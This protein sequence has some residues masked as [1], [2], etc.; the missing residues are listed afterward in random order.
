MQGDYFDASPSK[1]LCLCQ[2][3]LEPLLL[4]HSEKHGFP[5]RWNT[6][7]VSFTE[8]AEKGIVISTLL[9]VKSP[10]S[11]PSNLQVQMDPTVP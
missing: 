1:T 5:T 7:L 8:D 3:D 4:E 2:S 9:Q 11:V 6:R 10:L